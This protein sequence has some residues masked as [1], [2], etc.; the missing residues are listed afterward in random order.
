[1]GE[2]LKKA[3]MA[4]LEIAAILALAMYLFRLAVCY[5]SR[6]WW[7]LLILAL[8]IAAGIFGWR[9]WKNHHDAY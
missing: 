7:V 1:L 4:V 3:V 5:L 9:W 2:G 6:I 8:V